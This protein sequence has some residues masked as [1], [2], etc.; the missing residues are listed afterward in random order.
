MGG[1]V[2]RWVDE[3]RT[4]SLLTFWMPSTR[5]RKTK[6]R[7]KV[8]R[9]TN[10]QP[11]ISTMSSPLEPMAAATSQKVTKP[12]CWFFVWGSWEVGWVGGW[13]KQRGLE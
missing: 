6:P 11:Q 9:R 4:G 5:L 13:R 12:T 3:R 8:L 7:I 1:W 10:I 2:G